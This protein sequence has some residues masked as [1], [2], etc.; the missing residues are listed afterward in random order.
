MRI[1]TL[2][3]IHWRM[4]ARLNFFVALAAGI[5]LILSVGSEPEGAEGI[6]FYRS[7]SIIF[8]QAISNPFCWDSDSI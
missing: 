3:G 5:T 6:F 2:V 7:P 4:G 8:Y 1:H